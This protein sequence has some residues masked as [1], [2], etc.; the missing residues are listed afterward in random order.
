VA[1]VEADQRPDQN[2]T[3]GVLLDRWMEIVDHEL[4]TAETTAGYV[5]RTLRPSES[6]RPGEPRYV[7]WWLRP[8]GRPAVPR[9]HCARSSSDSYC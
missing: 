1:R 6:A 9:D 5:R 3:V 2:A 7:A 8:P 4:S